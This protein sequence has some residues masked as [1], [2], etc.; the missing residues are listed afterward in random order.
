[1]YD[2]NDEEVFGIACCSICKSCFVYKKM[3]SSQ[4]RSMG[5]KNLLDHMKL[6][7]SPVSPHCSRTTSDSGGSGCSLTS[8]GTLDSFV[9][10]T[11]KRVA[12][13]AKENV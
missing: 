4:E 9:K 11:G 8:R 10:R 5:T 12:E 2:T 6:Y 13:Q 1:M 3:V 7:N